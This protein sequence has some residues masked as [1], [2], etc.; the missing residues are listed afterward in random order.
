MSDLQTLLQQRR[1]LEIEIQKANAE[2]AQ[3]QR[4]AAQARAEVEAKERAAVAVKVGKLRGEVERLTAKLGSASLTEKR[5]LY[6]LIAMIEGQLE[7]LDPSE[8]EAEPNGIGTKMRALYGRIKDR[9]N[10]S[11]HYWRNIL[12]R[13]VLAV[14]GF[15]LSV[16][17]TALQFVEN[18]GAG[19]EANVRIQHL[20]VATAIYLVLDMNNSIILFFRNPDLARYGNPKTDSVYSKEIDFEKLTIPW[21]RLLIYYLPQM[22]RLLILAFLYSCLAS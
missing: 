17:D 3:K 11:A 6:S 13:L 12:L 21:Q 1:T 20:F 5:D 2:V 22:F 14:V 9:I 18:T 16:H 7:V 10:G 19:L 15:Y 8:A 4:E